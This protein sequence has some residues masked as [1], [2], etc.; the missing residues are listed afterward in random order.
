M[1]LPNAIR[2]PLVAVTILVLLVVGFVAMNVP[3]A[4]VGLLGGD[5]GLSGTIVR[6]ELRVVGAVYALAA[7]FSVIGLVHPRFRR[8]SRKIVVFALASVLAARFVA[9]KNLEFTWT[10]GATTAVAVLLFAF[11]IT[12]VQRPPTDEELDAEQAGRPTP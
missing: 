5:L 4:Y 2:G 6:G 8:D 9:A 1:R 12:E 3:S 10:D 11:A 7:L